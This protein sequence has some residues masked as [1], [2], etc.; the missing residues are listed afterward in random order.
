MCSNCS[1][2]IFPFQSLLNLDLTDESI[3]SVPTPISR[4][5]I[6][7]LRVNFSLNTTLGHGND[8]ESNEFISLHAS[9]NCD[10][11]DA[12][13][14]DKLLTNYNTSDRSLKIFHTNIRS[15]KSNHDNLINLLSSIKTK[16]DV[17]SLT[18][19]WN[20]IVNNGAFLPDSIEGYNDYFGTPGTTQ[21]S[22]CGLYIREGINYTRRHK[23][24][25]H[26][27]D[28]EHEFEATWIEI[29]NEKGKNFMVASIYRHPS[30]DDS[31]F[32]K[33]LNGT[34]NKITNENKTV[35]ITGD[36][37]INLLNHKH[38]INAINLLETMY[39]N[40]FHPHILLPTR[41]VDNARPSL[42][43]NIFTNTLDPDII[44]GNLLGKITDHLPNFIVLNNAKPPDSKIKGA[45]R[46]YSK[47]I[48]QDYLNDVHKP[49]N[50]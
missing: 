9:N 37:N 17:I 47:S 44:S 48:E 45:K 41:I 49:L 20:D 46:D 50:I 29:I 22:G 42:L 30:K 43:D 4:V 21:N 6:N 34:F 40:M 38:D 28:H 3:N 1:L 23:L 15:L 26:F 33:Y 13:D 14:I 7:E 32:I 24:D 31:P 35:I 18:E 12:A 19:T 10:Y 36:F 11:Y 27:H 25:Y 16:F 2:T 39:F 5:H 8:D